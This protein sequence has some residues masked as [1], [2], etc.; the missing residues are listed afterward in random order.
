MDGSTPFNDWQIKVEHAKKGKP[1]D[2]VRNQGKDFGDITT[3]RSD[4]E[5]E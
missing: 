3:G 2:A 1:F 5:E 4:D